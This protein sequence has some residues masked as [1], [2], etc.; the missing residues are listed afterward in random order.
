ML[1]FENITAPPL[2]THGWRQVLTL[3]VTRN[4]WEVDWNIFYPRIDIGGEFTGITGCEF[5]VFNYLMYFFDLCFGYQDWYGRLINSLVSCASLWYFYQIIKRVS[6]EPIA[7]FSTLFLGTSIFFKYSRKTMP[8]TFSLGLVIIGVYFAM[9]FLENKQNRHLILS[10]LLITFGILSKMPS[11]CFLCFLI[12]PFLDKNVAMKNKIK[13]AATISVGVGIMSMWYFVWVP[14]LIDTYKYPFYWPYSLLDG[15]KEL[16]RLSES[17]WV[18]FNVD[19]FGTR[20]SFLVC[21]LGSGG[22]LLQKQRQL[23][24]IFATYSLIFFFFILK[25]GVTFP[26]HEYYIIPYLPVMC[27]AAGYFIANWQINKYVKVVLAF[28]F[29]NMNLNQHRLDV[30]TPAEK[31]YFMTLTN[32]VDKYVGKNEKIMTNGGGY[33]PFMMYWSHRKGWV[34]ENPV[35]FKTDWMPDFKRD[36]LRYIVIDRHDLEQPLPYLLVFEDANFRIYKP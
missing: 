23:S 14:Y 34:H 15:W 24:A 2:D 22:I 32:I 29:L 11:A 19:A 27:T 12:P 17:A 3:M 33:N 18:R 26:T 16:V 4:F 13:L 7:F 8:D 35:L 31:R 20:T 9:R 30:A 36:G 10:F 21:M 5:P 1:H 28:L 6:S 25:T